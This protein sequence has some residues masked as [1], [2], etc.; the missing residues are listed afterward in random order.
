MTSSPR[1]QKQKGKIVQRLEN[2]SQEEI[3]A[4]WQQLRPRYFKWLGLFALLT[5][6]TY[7]VNHALN[8]QFTVEQ[9]NANNMLV[10]GLSIL[11][12]AFHIS[13]IFCVLFVFLVA[14]SLFFGRVPVKAAAE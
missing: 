14:M 7:L 13:S 12:A 3:A 9:L 1:K 2:V 8:M 11:N 6:I 10:N 5:V 4:R